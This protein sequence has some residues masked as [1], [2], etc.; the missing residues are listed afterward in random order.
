MCRLL[1]FAAPTRRTV[2]DM[3]GD[4]QLAV[5]EDMARL[6]R[7]G[8]GTSW[9]DERGGL[10]LEAD[11]QESSGLNDEHLFEALNTHHASAR[12]VHLRLATD[13]M[14]CTA[15]NTHPFVAE[16]FAFEHNG[17]LPDVAAVE[18]LLSPSVWARI[19]GDTDSERYFGLIRTYIEEGKSV[20]AATVKAVRKL[21]SMFPH[22]S[23]NALMLSGTQLI[24]VH[25]SSQAPSPVHEFDKRGIALDTLPADHIDEYYVMRMRRHDDGSVVIASSGLD[26]EQWEPLP[27]DSV[28]VVDLATLALES[29][30][31]D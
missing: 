6:H 29:F 25:A 11:K 5:F 2:A 23:L 14:L 16:D 4:D 21:R 17:S 8:W 12:I 24:A 26:I 7:D 27:H 9:I 19:K 13:G 1:G 30:P 22:S 15:E 18:R 31:L 10:G 28:T 20:Q 3:L